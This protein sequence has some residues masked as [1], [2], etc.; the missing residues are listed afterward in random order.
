M[1]NELAHVARQLSISMNLMQLFA[2]GR[3]DAHY[4]M[5]VVSHARFANEEALSDSAVVVVFCPK[6]VRELAGN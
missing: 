6:R 4:K 3:L 5:L 2:V 1:L